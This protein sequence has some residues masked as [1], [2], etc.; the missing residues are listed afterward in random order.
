MYQ[1][2]KTSQNN[3]VTLFYFKVFYVD[4]AEFMLA[5]NSVW[6]RENLNCMS[7]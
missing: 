3:S 1:V 4:K 5:C 7:K 2:V 6:I